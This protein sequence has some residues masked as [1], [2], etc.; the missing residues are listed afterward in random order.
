MKDA[1]FRDK[2]RRDLLTDW[3]VLRYGGGVINDTGSRLGT[4]EPRI[5]SKGNAQAATT[6]R[7]KV[8]RTIARGGIT[9]SSEETSVMEADAKG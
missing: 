4:W 1:I 6:A 9:R 3:T 8:P 2:S 7:V 5:E